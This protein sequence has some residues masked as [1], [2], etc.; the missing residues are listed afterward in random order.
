MKAVKWVVVLM[1]ICVPLAA[2]AEV[3]VLTDGSMLS[4][5]VTLAEDTLTVTNAA[6]EFAV[7]RA[8]IASVRPSGVSPAPVAVMPA[9]GPVFITPGEGQSPAM[10]AAPAAMPYAVTAMPYTAANPDNPYAGAAYPY[11]YAPAN[12]YAGYPGS[13]W[14]SYPSGWGVNPAGGYAQPYAMP[15]YQPPVTTQEMSTPYD[16][17][18]QVIGAA[19]PLRRGPGTQYGIIHSVNRDDLLYRVGH[20]DG[21]YQVITR[22]GQA[23]WINAEAVAAMGNGPDLTPYQWDFRMSPT[24]LLVTTQ[25]LNVRSGPGLNYPVIDNLYHNDVAKTIAREGAW[26]RIQY[27]DPATHTG[28][29]HNSYVADIYQQVKEM[30]VQRAEYDEVVAIG[31]A[32][33]PALQELAN[34]EDWRV[35]Y[36]AAMVREKILANRAFVPGMTSFNYERPITSR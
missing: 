9:A 1:L 3:V 28:W 16:Q 5:R 31:E 8:R 7:P 25:T 10:Y 13:G 36:A 35:R 26:T 21:W 12:P 34:N 27:L 15:A 20:T 32:A 30:I 24:D 11:G 23:G 2:Q 14:E 4:G 22:S 6:G 33:L 19:A 17:L 29:V 18:L